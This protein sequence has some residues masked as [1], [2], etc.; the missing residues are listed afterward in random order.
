MANPL[1]LFSP[2]Y[3]DAAFR[4][5]QAAARVGAHLTRH[6]TPELAEE[7]PLTMDVATVGSETPRH[8]VVVS[9]GVH[10]IEGFFGSSIQLRWLSRVA[11]GTSLP[12][13]GKTI[14]SLSV[15]ECMALVQGGASMRKARAPRR[16]KNR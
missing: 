3:H 7:P 2:D 11:S 14:G 15:A 1:D 12:L 4:F 10:G 16:A 9:S 13:I 6:T 5:R 8:T